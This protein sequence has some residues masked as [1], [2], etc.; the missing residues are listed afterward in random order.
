M[1]YVKARDVYKDPAAAT[2]RSNKMRKIYREHACHPWRLG[3]N[4][5][6]KIPSTP[7]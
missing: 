3:A 7:S 5:V 6:A 4:M 1:E 2:R